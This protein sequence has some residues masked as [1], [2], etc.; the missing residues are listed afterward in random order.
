M[1]T[2][3]IL[4]A[5]PALSQI[6]TLKNT[7]ELI[8]DFEVVITDS[9]ESILHTQ[10][11]FDIII[12][13]ISFSYDS[14]RHHLEKDEYVFRFLGSPF[15][16]FNLIKK[17]KTPYLIYSAYNS[18]LINDVMKSIGI[19]NSVVL[20]KPLLARDLIEEVNRKLVN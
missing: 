13:G 18:S 9:F 20:F 3:R 12:L 2:K 4:L 10:K 5:D 14:C 6:A 15:P 7:L 8:S 11:E 16:F 19:E 17:V 1:K